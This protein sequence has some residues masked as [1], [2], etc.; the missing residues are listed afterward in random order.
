M[1]DWKWP[2]QAGL[3][4]FR[5]L[6]PKPCPW[7]VLV[8]ESVG[9]RAGGNHGA[10]KA[11]RQPACQAWWNQFGRLHTEVFVQKM[12]FP[13]AQRTNMLDLSMVEIE[14][15]GFTRFSFVCF[16]NSSTMGC[17]IL[18]ALAKHVSSSLEPIIFYCKP[19]KIAGNSA[20]WLRLAAYMQRKGRGDQEWHSG[21]AMGAF[22]PC[23]PKAHRWWHR[24]GTFSLFFCWS[25]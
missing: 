1:L 7:K 12:L 6:N 16:M 22:K 10:A 3:G 18:N 20:G 24:Q 14:K 9:A 17:L 23:T 21:W 13:S 8:S 25:Q 11:A 15:H 19:S 2:V 5:V 4:I